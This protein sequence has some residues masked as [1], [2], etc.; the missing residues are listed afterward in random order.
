M[1]FLLNLFSLHVFPSTPA[2][3]FFVSRSR[4]VVFSA[5]FLHL[6]VLWFSYLHFAS[7]TLCVLMWRI[8][9]TPRLFTT[10]GAALCVC[11]EH[12]VELTYPCP[13]RGFLM[14]L[15]SAAPLFVAYNSASRNETTTSHC[16][17]PQCLLVNAGPYYFAY[18]M[19]TSQPSSH[20]SPWGLQRCR[21]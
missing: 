5:D 8:C 19:I 4:N 11:P 7:T 14:P 12:H 1:S 21:Q 15:P 2:F 16:V 3:T 10:P 20:A 18:V 13:L 17:E 9:P 6:H